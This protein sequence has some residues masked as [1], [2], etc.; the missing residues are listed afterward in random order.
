MRLDSAHEI[1]AGTEF[2]PTEDAY[3]NRRTFQATVAAVCLLSVYFLKIRIIYYMGEL[4]FIFMLWNRGTPDAFQPG[5]KRP[6]LL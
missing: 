1:A 3:A 5:T 2:V 6:R 4:T